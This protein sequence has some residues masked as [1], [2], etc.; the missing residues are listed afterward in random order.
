MAAVSDG[1]VAITSVANWVTIVA[2]EGTNQAKQRLRDYF[3][4][5][6]EHKHGSTYQQADFHRLATCNAIID[7]IGVLGF[8][9]PPL[10][11][12]AQSAVNDLTVSLGYRRRVDVVQLRKHLAPV[13]VEPAEVLLM[14]CVKRGR[15]GG[16]RGGGR[17]NERG[18][19]GGGEGDRG[20]GG[21]GRK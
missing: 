16:V 3:S 6:P 14:S 9:P 4:I 17:G 12:S 21:R 18:R 13:E 20:R 1:T 5:M 2:N 11:R 15:G 10:A 19:G 8:L 7:S